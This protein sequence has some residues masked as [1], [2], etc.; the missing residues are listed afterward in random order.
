[1]KLKQRLAMMAAATTMLV[2]LLTGCSAEKAYPNRNITLIVPYGAG[3]TADTV[4]R[5]LAAQ[6]SA[7]LG[8]TIAVVNQGG[9]SG[10]IGCKTVLDAA[11]DGYTLLL[12]ADSLGTQRSMGISQMSYADFA[13]IIVAANDPK[14]IVVAASS[15]YETAEQLFNDLKARPGKV[16][17]SHTGPGGSGHVQGLIYEQFD[18]KP[19]MTSYNSGSECLLAV[20]SGEVDFT[21]ANLS[22]L[23]GYIESGELRLLAVSATERLQLYPELPALTEFYPE[24]VRYLELPFSP[25]SLMVRADTPTEIIE[26]LR[27]AADYAIGTD[28]WNSFADA[29]CLDR[30]YQSYPNEQSAREFYARFEATVS[31][32]L[33]D[34]G[35]AQHSP[36]DFGIER[37]QQ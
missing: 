12:A 9:A 25:L 1:M 10:S 13:P 24:M 32:L 4:G 6:M 29:N 18:M 11:A 35:A 19:A 8:Q 34:A 33:Y 23:G 2:A 20:L 36:A 15:H 37:P 5:Q 21:N 27:S 3:G 31:W 26:R 14:V 16:R 30:L 28:E 7:E 22:T 17:M